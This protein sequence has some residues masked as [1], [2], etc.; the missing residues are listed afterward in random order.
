MN[1]RVVMF[2]LASIFI[3][4]VL[5][6][7]AG[8]TES[9]DAGQAPPAQVVVIAQ[10]AIVPVDGT[11]EIRALTEGTVQRVLVRTGDRVAAGQLLVEVDS[12]RFR[13]QVAERRAELQAAAERL[14]LVREGVRPEEQ[15][16]RRAAAEAAQR[17][18]A[19][20]HDRWTRLSTLLSRQAASDQAATAARLEYEAAVARSRE[21]AL[22]AEAA[23]AGGRPAAITEAESALDAAMAA[24]REA[25]VLFGW[26]RIV[27]PA[28]GVVLDRLI[29]PGD[30]IRSDLAAP[31]VFRIA[32]P[33]RVEVRAEVE[34][35][36][37]DQ[38]RIGQVVELRMPGNANR[39][40]T[41]RI[42]R[43]AADMKRRE[44]GADDAQ[45]RAD[46]WVRSIWI[47][48]DVASADRL[49]PIGLRLEA[50]IEV[51]GGMQLSKTDRAALTEK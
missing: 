21:T 43:I 42:A 23:R 6:W 25:E 51:D 1:R 29:N 34:A 24:L 13:T 36:H 12:P 41:G 35:A 22:L 3:A 2:S 17:Q 4:T 28:D 31:L 26:S 32:D 40:G 18:E 45:L 16:A 7:S 37:I 47:A 20:A 10:A 48:L 38:V 44:I 46:A 30:V 14:A 39:L 9:P 49:L 15:E 19:L 11:S 33:G 8:G 27:A 50:R 5:F